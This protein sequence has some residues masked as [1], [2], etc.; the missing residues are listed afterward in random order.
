MAPARRIVPPKSPPPTL[1]HVGP[2]QL[3][4]LLGEGAMTRVFQARS[5]D[6]RDRGLANYAVKFLR[7][8]WCDD[9]QALL[10]L[11]R[12]AAIGRNFS[13]PHI[14]PVLT[15]GV[16][17]A[18]YYIAMPHLVGATLAS[19]I[20]RGNLPEIPVAL[21][22]ARQIADGLASLHE[23]TGLMHCDVKPANILVA[24][25]GHATLLDLGFAQPIDQPG[26]V[27]E[28]PV[29]GTLNYVAPEMIVSSQAADAR[30][31]LFSLGVT[32]YESLTGRL[33]FEAESPTEIPVLHPSISAVPIQTRN[34]DL[35][36]PVAELVHGMIAKDPRHRPASLRAVADRLAI[37]EIATFDQRQSA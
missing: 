17:E 12:E 11:R 37:L 36:T 15:A 23:T 3:V 20:A 19:Q 31:D 25:D 21:W 2:W 9:P 6:G 18:P 24:P 32:L 33:P 5:I 22:I 26:S 16:A 13:H 8:E 4:R 28:R 34:P 10:I 27:A 14:V 7:P 30:S 35:P 29:V 1:G